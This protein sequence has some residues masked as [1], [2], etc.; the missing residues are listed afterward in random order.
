MCYGDN[1]GGGGLVTRIVELDEG[2]GWWER[3][4]LGGD[5]DDDDVM[6]ERKG[7]GGDDWSIWKDGEKRKERGEQGYNGQARKNKIYLEY[8]LEL[9]R[10]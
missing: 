8:T 4:G 6:V 7:G 1:D 9:N 5:D 2:V 10:L 3:C